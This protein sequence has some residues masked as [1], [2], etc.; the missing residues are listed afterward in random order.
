MTK[1]FML[2]AGALVLALTSGGWI[3]GSPSYPGA[4]WLEAL[5]KVPCQDIAPIGK[6]DLKVNATVV[7]G[8]TSYANPVISDHELVKALDKHCHL[9]R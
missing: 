2:L 3:H 5:E 9:K 4:T 1:R 7:V 8:G 6:D